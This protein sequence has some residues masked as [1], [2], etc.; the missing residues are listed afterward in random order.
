M[1]IQDKNLGKYNRAGIFIEETDNS[2]V[3]LPTQNDQLINLIPGFSKKGPVNNPVYVTNQTDF[4]NIFGDIDKGLERKGSYFHRTCLKMLE[5]GS[6][7]A[8]NLLSTNDTRDLISW[9]SVSCAAVFENNTTKTMPYSRVFNRQDFWN[10]DDESFLDYVKA[11]TQDLSRLLHITNLGEKTI[12][13]FMY[14]SKITGFD[15]TAENWYGGVTKVPAYINAKDWISDYMVSVLILEGDWTDYNSL[16]VDTTWGKYFTTTGLNKNVVQNF[17]NEVNVTTLAYYDASLIPYFKDITGRDMYIKSLINSNT[18]RTGLF[19]AYNEELLLDSDYP[20]GKMDLIGDGLVGLDNTTID[21]LSYNETIV[22]TLTFNNTSLNSL[23]NVFGNYSSMNSAFSTS[24][25]SRNGD[26]TNWFVDATVTPSVYG[27]STQ[28]TTLYKVDFAS[29]TGLSFTN[30]TIDT[31][32]QKQFVTGDVVYLNRTFGNLLANTAYYVIFHD[33]STIS[34]ATS[35]ANAILGTFITFTSTSV[36]TPLYVQRINIV[37]TIGTFNLNG[38]TYTLNSGVTVF[39]PLTITDL[40]TGYAHNRYDVLYLTAGSTTPNILTGTQNDLTTATKP[41]FTTDY[42]DAIILGYVHHHIMSGATTG[43]TSSDF[44]ILSDYTA[45]TVDGS[46]YVK[47]SNIVVS[48]GTTSSM[49]KITFNNTLGNTSLY[50]DYDKLRLRAAYTEIQSMLSN[51]MGVIINYNNGYKCYITNPTCVDFSTS[52]NAYI[53]F[54]VTGLWSDYTNVNDILLYYVDN[55]FVLGDNETDRLL[56]SLAPL[57]SLNTSGQ[58]VAAGVIGIYSDFYLDYYNGIIN[59]GNYGYVDNNTGSTKI[60]IKA[61]F[62]TDNQLYVDFMDVDGISPIS[63]I[64]W[65]NINTYNLKFNLVSNTS[66]YKQ[67]LEIE[68]VDPVKKALNLVYEINVDKTRYSEVKKGD[69]LEAY[70]NEADYEQGGSLYG[71][72]PRKLTR[73][74]NVTISSTNPTWKVIS[75]DAPIKITTV[76]TDDQTTIYP[77][78]DVYISTYKGIKLTPFTIS[79]DS[80]PN[81][82]EERQS[83][84]LN[85]IGK[86]TNLAKGL[87]NK[88][89]ITWRYLV[90]SFGNGLSENSKQ[91]YADLCGMK[92]NCFAFVN[93]PSV[94]ELKASASPSFVNDDLTL[95]TDFL[96]AGGDESKNPAFLYSFASGVGRSCMG[97]FFP[98][99]TVNDNGIP[100][101]V[102]PAAWVATTYMAKHLTSSSSIYPWTIAAGISDG[103]ILNISDVEM[104]MSDDDLANLYAMN[105]NP[106]VK[107]RNAGYCIET[108]DTAQVFPYTS[109]SV[110]HSREVLIDLENEMYDMLLKYQWKFNTPEVRGEIKFRAD[111]ICK[112]YQERNAL[113]NFKNIID[114]SN[115]TNYLIDL[116]M[117]V[118]D[119]QIELIKGMGIIVNNITILKKGDIESSGFT[120]Q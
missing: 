61:W 46:G 98:Y 88:N 15:V 20:T 19:C 55:E 112:T 1:P 14:K 79:V 70:Y 2:L 102:P 109:L 26:K 118:L 23:G 101:N 37:N 21:F 81:G 30:I 117:G 11:S 92:L 72:D 44:V 105:L 95:N 5:S 13:V 82:T 62:N 116:Q 104:D 52:Y 63:I 39:Q 89:K 53:T 69:F 25:S 100:K 10:R 87:V 93:A 47:M 51:N 119:T 45:V 59:N 84:I 65:S 3:T 38:N 90:D 48:S 56:S 94:K 85:V 83:S 86:T 34:L 9:K 110:I 29:T 6:I 97:Y 35:Y 76:G 54:S 8:L 120:A 27:T 28:S 18:N 106:I 71:T 111:K 24:I 4:I 58:T 113:Y 12:T 74:V 77:Q 107:K 91:Q 32:K 64:D 42:N 33:T 7:W 67:T 43:Q 80:M 41:N 96:K 78:L 16:S 60:T 114:E 99:V 36:T 40:S 50:N 22:E 49:I 66:N 115:N 68:Y 17:V 103:K 57:E 31:T 108:E 75:T 73:I